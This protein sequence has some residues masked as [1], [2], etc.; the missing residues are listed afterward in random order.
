M[1]I[2]IVFDYLD[3]D[4]LD[5]DT[6]FSISKN[7]ASQRRTKIYVEEGSYISVNDAV[8]ALIV[9]SANDVA[10][11][12]AENISGS[13]REF[14]KLMTKYSKEIGMKKTTFKNAEKTQIQFI[15]IVCIKCVCLF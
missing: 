1:T 12:V 14:A 6:K 13:E 5:W 11:V 4:K 9:K 2:Y 7:A 8:R 15:S 3:K 10:T